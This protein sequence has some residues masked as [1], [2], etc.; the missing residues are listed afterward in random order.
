MR[1][2]KPATP[3]PAIPRQP[4]RPTDPGGKSNLTG[5]EIEIGILD[6][7]GGTLASTGRGVHMIKERV[8]RFEGWNLV[9]LAGVPAVGQMFVGRFNTIADVWSDTLGIL[10]NTLTKDGGRITTVAANY[11]AAHPAGSGI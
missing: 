8:P 1:P 11:R 10:G 9:P 3:A 6:T 7:F 4:T 2:A 5:Y